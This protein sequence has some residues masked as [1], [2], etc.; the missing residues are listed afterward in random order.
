M[1]YLS[2]VSLRR[3][4]VRALDRVA[5][6]DFLAPRIEIG[7]VARRFEFERNA[8]FLDA[9]RDFLSL[10]RGGEAANPLAPR[11]DRMRGVADLVAAAREARTFRGAVRMEM[12]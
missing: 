9:M 8:M 12:E 2:P 3:G 5:E 6:I 4:A 10:V 1:D 11:L 7:G